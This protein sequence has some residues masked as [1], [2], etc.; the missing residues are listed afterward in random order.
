MKQKTALRF[1]TR[2]IAVIFSLFVFVSLLMFTVG[3]LVGKG[4]T[5]AR[6][7]SQAKAH[8]AEGIE[9]LT[10]DHDPHP[11]NSV[12]MGA[13]HH[14][15]TAHETAPPKAEEKAPAASHGEGHGA[16]TAS[17]PAAEGHGEKPAPSEEEKTPVAEQT[18]KPEKEAPPLKLIPLRPTQAESTGVNLADPAREA[19][20]LL[21]NPKIVSLLEPEENKEPG[22][23]VSSV[24][25]S[26]A[27]KTVS[28]VSGSYTVQVGSYPNEA[29]AQERVESLK[30]LGFP[31]AFFS[32]KELDSARGTWYRVWLGQYPD[33][34]TAKKM[35]DQLQA[36]GEVKNYIVRK[37]N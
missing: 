10:K 17:A 32:A 28:S 29:A 21:K 13:A 30:K 15:E 8:S 20:E 31:Q 5:Q 19:N 34:Q 12:S 9:P 24:N 1:D 37:N 3:I 36:R 14:G 11:G 25:P 18:H 2:E 27:A 26:S 6:F 23:S 35:G 22:R 16:S 33:H 7:E 4:L